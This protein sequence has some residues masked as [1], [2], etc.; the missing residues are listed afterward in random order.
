MGVNTIRVQSKCHLPEIVRML[1]I[2]SRVGSYTFSICHL[3]TK[4]ADLFI[5]VF[6]NLIEN[7][8]KK[9]FHY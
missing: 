7:S 3:R 2:Q 9:L 8:G 4:R 5:Y 1:I 6:T